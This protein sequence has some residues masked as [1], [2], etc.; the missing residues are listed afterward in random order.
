MFDAKRLLD[1]LVG[2]AAQIGGPAGQPGAG[3][4][5]PGQGGGVGLGPR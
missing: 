4:G 5:C 3:P 1:A 2:A